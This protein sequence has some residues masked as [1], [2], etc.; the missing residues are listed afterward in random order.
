MGERFGPGL[1][2]G[3]TVEKVGLLVKGSFF[4]AEDGSPSPINAGARGRAI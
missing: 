4:R 3:E 2:Q 1:M